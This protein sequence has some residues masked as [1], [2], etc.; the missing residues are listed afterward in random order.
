MN[1]ASEE[2]TWEALDDQY[3]G[4]RTVQRVDKSVSYLVGALYAD[5]LEVDLNALEARVR[6][7]EAEREHLRGAATELAAAMSLVF[8][9][10]T[11]PQR[12]A[13]ASIHAAMAHI[14]RY[15]A[16]LREAEAKAALA[17]ELATKLPIWR[18]NI[19]AYR[20]EWKEQWLFGEL[21]DWLAR[22]R[23]ALAVDALKASANGEETR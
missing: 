13:L 7:A 11:T 1:G 18:K 4:V 8:V 12:R 2:T 23:D 10:E 5:R 17:D 6:K 9:P 20:G 3:M 15:G 21:D 14:K 19:L 16:K 22:Y